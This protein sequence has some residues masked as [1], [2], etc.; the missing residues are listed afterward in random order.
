MTKETWHISCVNF[1]EVYEYGAHLSFH[2]VKMDNY[3]LRCT[4]IIWKDELISDV[5]YQNF[6]WSLKSILQNKEITQNSPESSLVWFSVILLTSSGHSNKACVHC[7]TQ[8]P[9]FIFLSSILRYQRFMSLLKH[10]YF[11]NSFHSAWCFECILIPTARNC[12]F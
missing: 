7:S 5:S 9:I 4:D 6:K 2:C 1:L 10:C 11:V 8:K 3:R 12:I